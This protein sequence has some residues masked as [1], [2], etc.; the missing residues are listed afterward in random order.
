M[1]V[2]FDDTDI[3]VIKDQIQNTFE[4]FVRN[5]VSERAYQK[6]IRESATEAVNKYFDECVGFDMNT[7][8]KIIQEQVQIEVAKRVNGLIRNL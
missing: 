6:K 5:T 1:N 2:T 3:Q 4:Y 8:S 7:L